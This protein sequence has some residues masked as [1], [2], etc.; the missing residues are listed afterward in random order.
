LW[1]HQIYYQV[2]ST[3]TPFPSGVPPPWVALDGGKRWSLDVRRKGSPLAGRGII[4][5]GE[6]LACVSVTALGPHFV[7]R[8][9]DGGCHRCGIATSSSVEVQRSWFNQ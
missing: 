2:L 3:D 8:P 4:V 7:E 9:P 5:S 1:C 6:A